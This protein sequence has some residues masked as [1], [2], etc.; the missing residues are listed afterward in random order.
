[1]EKIEIEQ[2]KLPYGEIYV[3]NIESRDMAPMENV[4]MVP[5]VPTENL[6]VV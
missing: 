3:R 6:A 1:M 5:I 2:Q 4:V